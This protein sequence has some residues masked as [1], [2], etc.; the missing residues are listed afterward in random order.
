MTRLELVLPGRTV[1]A[2]QLLAFVAVTA[3]AQNSSWRRLPQTRRVN[4]FREFADAH[5]RVDLTESPRPFDR[6]FL[7]FAATW[8]NPS[9]SPMIGY[10]A[11]NPWT[12]DVWDVNAC[13]L[14]EVGNLKKRWDDVRKRSSIPGGT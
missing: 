11:V 9:G 8:P 10:Y 3:L 1:L 7:Y 4:F 12:G 13:K 6:D 2:L 5:G 14:Y